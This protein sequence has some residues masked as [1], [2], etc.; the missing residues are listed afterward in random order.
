MRAMILALTL[1]SCL[2]HQ[3]SAAAQREQVLARGSDIVPGAIVCPDF[4][5]LQASYRGF[6][7]R[8]GPGPN[9]EYFG[10]SL[11]MPGTVMYLDGEDPGGAPLVT[12]TFPDGRI[13]RGVTLRD[14]V[15]GFVRKPPKPVP[16]FQKATKST[17]IVPT[18]RAGRS[19]QAS[20]SASPLPPIHNSSDTLCEPGRQ[21]NGQ[22]F[23]TALMDL[24]RRWALTPGW[25]RAKCLKNSTL[26][27]MD[28][29]LIRHTVAWLKTNEG[30]DTPWL[31][32]QP[33]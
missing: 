3:T 30:A 13:V 31:L 28:D 23:S 14:M 20:A 6:T 26:P 25:L 10:C 29:C 1:L 33:Q 24:Q 27:A 18:A 5:A 11:I 21:C 7:A 19:Q 16:Q 4:R 32:A 8:R 2:Y 9:V 12:A 15:E 17:E 22:E